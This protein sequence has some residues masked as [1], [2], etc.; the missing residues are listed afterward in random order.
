MKKL[1]ILI[2]GLTLSACSLGNPNWLLMEYPIEGDNTIMKFPG[3]RADELQAC[4]SQYNGI[5]ERRNRDTDYKGKF[6]CGS[7]C[8]F[9]KEW[10]SPLCDELVDL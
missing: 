8:R 6:Q 4:M 3:V 10:G 5:K 1:V 2:I 9:S 7:N